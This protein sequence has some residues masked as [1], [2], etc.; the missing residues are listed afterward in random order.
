MR[1]KYF[2]I[3][4]KIAKMKSRT[5]RTKFYLYKKSGKAFKIL[6]IFHA[7]TKEKY[8]RIVSLYVIKISAHLHKR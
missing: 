1:Y 2:Q 3:S 5:S 6:I 7:H 8:K 4:T